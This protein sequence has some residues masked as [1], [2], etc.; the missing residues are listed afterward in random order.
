MI[1]PSA[2][3]FHCVSFISTWAGGAKPAVAEDTDP[4]RR[5]PY[6]LVKDTVGNMRGNGAAIVKCG[7][8]DVATATW[9][10]ALLAVLALR[11]HIALDCLVAG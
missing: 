6:K 2:C 8:V 10:D 11:L 9:T 3:Y 5:L 1:S 7:T 4:K